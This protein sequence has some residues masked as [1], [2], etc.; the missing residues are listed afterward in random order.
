MTT[1]ISRLYPD[2][3]TATTIAGDLRTAGFPAGQV[4]V[5]HPGPDMAAQLS[6]AQVPDATAAAYVGAASAGNAVV[7]ARAEVTPLGAAL[8]AMDIVDSHP[9]IHVAG[10]DP[11]AYVRQTARGDLYLSILDDHPRW[12]SS[13]IRPGSGLAPGLI[14][15]AFGM[16][17]LR[18][19]RTG[20]SAIS[21]GRFM[22]RAFWPQKL[23]SEHRTKRSAM[24]GER[25][26][27]RWFWPMPLISHKGR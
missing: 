24:S 2:N 19:H 3:R 6:A 1:I 11:N 26:M 18:E 13:D 27:S 23:I 5:V 16:R 12:F 25:Y 22:S 21:G 7:V 17:M 15:A 20:R 4:D 14:S 9:S 10:A 8:R